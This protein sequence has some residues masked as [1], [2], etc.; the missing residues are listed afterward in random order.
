MDDLNETNHN[1][2]QETVWD[3]LWNLHHIYE[4]FQKM[5]AVLAGLVLACIFWAMPFTKIG[6]EDPWYFWV[7]SGLVAVA[8]STLIGWVF[9]SH[10]QK[11]KRR[12]E[13]LDQRP[14]LSE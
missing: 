14:T 8:A 1:T 12:P 6:S 2:P 7:G 10:P 11:K 4:F 13:G 3:E 9:F 5:K